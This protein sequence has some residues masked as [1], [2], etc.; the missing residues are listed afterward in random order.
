[1]ARTPSL[2]IRSGFALLVCL[3]VASI[4]SLI[5]I[6]IFQTIRLEIVE[7]KSLDEKTIADHAARSASEVTLASL[8]T[9]Q[10]KN[11][12]DQLK[13]GK[14]SSINVPNLKYPIAP[15][16]SLLNGSTVIRYSPKDDMVAIQSIVSVAPFSKKTSAQT[17][18]N[19]YFFK[20]ADLEKTL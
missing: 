19:E 20:L 10:G 16:F 13:S 6:G 8:R 5:A 11:W 2:P 12:I 17:S 14:V 3:A 9:A 15:N 1:M 4:C 7:A 18:T